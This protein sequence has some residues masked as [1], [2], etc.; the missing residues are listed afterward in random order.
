M[1]QEEQEIMVRSSDEDKREAVQLT[2][3][4]RIAKMAG[5]IECDLSTSRKDRVEIF[6][7]TPVR[8]SSLNVSERII[9][10]W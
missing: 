2:R 6:M 4:P 1:E 3:K 5:D 9:S 8:D 10:W 7:F